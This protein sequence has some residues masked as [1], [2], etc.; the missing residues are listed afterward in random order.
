MSYAGAEVL[1][2]SLSVGELIVSS[3]GAVFTEKLDRNLFKA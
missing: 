2:V 3:G 1:K